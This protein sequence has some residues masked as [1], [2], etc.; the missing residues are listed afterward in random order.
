MGALPAV[1]I[2]DYSTCCL[3]LIVLC[4]KRAA[5]VSAKGR[6]TVASNI[7]SYIER[8]SFKFPADCF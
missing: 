5:I 2:R 3:V 7:S 6:H 8:Q 4:E 1:N